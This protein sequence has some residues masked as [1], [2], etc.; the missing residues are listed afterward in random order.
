MKLDV[1]Q[2]QKVEGLV[3]LF[4]V[5]VDVEIATAGGRK[6]YPIEVNQAAQSFTFPGRQRAA[7]GAV[8]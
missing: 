6:T 8:R 2:T 1:N 5:P 4:D 7:N 3:G